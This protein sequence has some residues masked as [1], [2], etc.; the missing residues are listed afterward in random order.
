M[1]Q[2]VIASLILGL[3]G[4]VG[5]PHA[6]AAEGPLQGAWTMV[7]SDCS[8]SFE[9]SG[10]GLKFVDRGSS[11]Q[12][13]IIVSQ[14]TMMGPNSTCKIGRIAEQQGVYKVHLMCS[15]AIMFDDVSVLLKII[16]KDNFERIDPD[17]PEISRKYRRCSP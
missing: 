1:Q 7:G 6:L 11:V 12:T 15:T 8:D 13:G 4:M 2:T 9:P 14:D 16:D 17:F 3:I 5:A 10:S